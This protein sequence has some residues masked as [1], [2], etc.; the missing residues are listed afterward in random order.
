MCSSDLVYEDVFVS[1]EDAAFRQ[2][3][4]VNVVSQ[5]VRESLVER[6]VDPN[7]ILVNPN[8]ADPDVYRPI[9][10]DAKAALRAELGFGA[11]DCVIGFTGTFGGWHG[12]DVLAQAIPRICA[13][14]PTARF[15]LIGDGTH[16]HLVDAS[17][18]EHRLGDRVRS[19]G[20]VSQ[21][22]E[23]GRAHV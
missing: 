5:V 18:A 21:A 15:L 17:V 6:G 7:K 4:L 8:G 11:D 20:R 13:S 10:A 19:T 22:E 3:T 12:I 2:A 16:K 14:A 23:I 1:A 9:E